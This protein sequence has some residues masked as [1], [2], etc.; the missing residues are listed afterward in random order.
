VANTSMN[1]NQLVHHS[2]INA[3]DV[4]RIAKSL[5]RRRFLCLGVSGILMSIAALLA[6]NTKTN[7]QSSMQILVNSNLYE[8]VRL[9]N[10]QLSGNSEFTEPNLPVFDY[11]AQMKLMVSS[12]LIQKAVDILHSDYPDI[13]VEDI[14]GNNKNNKES[15]LVVSQLEGKGGVN[16]V[17]SPVIE[18]SFNHD[19]PVKTQ[20]VLKALQKVYQDYNLEQQKERLNQGLTF[21]ST[22][23]P[24]IKQE[25]SQAEENLENFRTKHNILDP[26]VQSKILLESL[27]NIQQ[28]RQTTRAQLKDVE[29]QYNNL[30]QKIAVLSEDAKIA[31]RLNQ[32]TRYQSLLNEVQ[33]TELASATE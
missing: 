26:E 3:V 5:L 25:L 30:E 22:R 12:K 19:D 10:I 20:R 23:L 27:A 24:Q 11:S 16:Q 8:G 7:Y 14:K 6:V 31:S 9:N 15:P 29:A 28:Q 32:S 18:V 13:T 1:Q 2:S 21:V 17:P 33:K 4:R